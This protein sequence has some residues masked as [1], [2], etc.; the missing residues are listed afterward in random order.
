MPKSSSPASG[1]PTPERRRRRRGAVDRLLTAPVP[2]GPLET[3]GR[4]VLSALAGPL[5]LVTPVAAAL[6]LAYGGL[7]LWTQRAPVLTARHRAEALCFA[8]AQRPTFAPP[9]A[10]ES[11]SALVRGRFSERTPVSLA[12]RETMH[13]SDD[14]VMREHAARV[15]D[16]DVSELWL[17]LPVARGGG[18]WLVV[19]W[20]EGSNLAIDTF[21]FTSDETDLTRDEIAWGSRLLAR[22]L[23]PENFRAATL[24]VVRLRI[25]PGATPLTFGPKGV[26]G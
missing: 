25:A 16:F 7:S 15:G 5:R 20:M 9:M 19:A 18:H 1:T 6:A 26:S 8:L 24:P 22:V 17:R 4:R 2:T 23:V 11:G 13:F 21:R 10:I 3:G 12:L 14:M